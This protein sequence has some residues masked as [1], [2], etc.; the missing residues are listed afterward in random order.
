MNADPGC[1]LTKRLEDLEE[2]LMTNTILVIFGPW[3]AREQRRE[4]LVEVNQVLR[5][6]ASFELVLMRM[7]S[8]E[9]SS[10]EPYRILTVCNSDLSAHPRRTYASFQTVVITMSVV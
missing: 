4:L 8:E 2:L 10:C 7:S 5:V 1:K 9:T 3:L 6:L